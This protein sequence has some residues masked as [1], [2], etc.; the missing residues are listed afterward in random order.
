MYSHTWVLRECWSAITILCNCAIPIEL[1]EKINT[2]LILQLLII[3]VVCFSHIFNVRPLSRPCLPSL[4]NC[5]YINYPRKN[6]SIRS[7]GTNNVNLNTRSKEIYKLFILYAHV[8][9]KCKKLN[10]TSIDRYIY[11]HCIWR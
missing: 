5:A 7:I 8:C 2:R 11:L 6:W 9:G 4:W 1:W 3:K 10:S